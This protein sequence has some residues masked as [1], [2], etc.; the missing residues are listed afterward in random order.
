MKHCLEMSVAR[1]WTK[2]DLFGAWRTV[3][4]VRKEKRIALMLAGMNQDPD[5]YWWGR[6]TA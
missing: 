3:I 1:T 6:R 5:D 4:E 2:E